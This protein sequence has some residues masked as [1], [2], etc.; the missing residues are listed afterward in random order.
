MPVAGRLLSTRYV[1]GDLFS[2]NQQTAEAIPNLFARNERLVCLFETAYGPMAVV[3]VGAMIVAGIETVW[4]GRACPARER[5]I[6][7][8]DYSTA[9]PPIELAAGAELGRFYLGSTAIVLF[10]HGAIELNGSLSA[11][12]PVKMGQLLGLGT[13]TGNTL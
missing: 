9:Q 4:A 8:Q 7:V 3:L 11:G 13:P 1:P 10:G 5:Q 12:S 6:R 2:V